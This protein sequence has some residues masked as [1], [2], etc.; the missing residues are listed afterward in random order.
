MNSNFQLGHKIFT[1]AIED[2]KKINQYIINSKPCFLGNSFRHRTEFDKKIEPQVLLFGV[3]NSIGDGQVLILGKKSPD[4]ETIYIKRVIYSV[5]ANGGFEYKLNGCRY[6][7]EAGFLA[8]FT[9]MLGPSRDNNNR[10]VE[11]FELLSKYETI[12]SD[13]DSDMNLPLLLASI[14]MI[15]I[16]YIGGYVSIFFIV[17]LLGKQNTWNRSKVRKVA[18]GYGLFVAGIVISSL[19]FT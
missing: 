8:L 9:R 2:S 18:I 14:F 1:F 10:E 7:D 11:V 5:E 19:L 3:T 17:F 12:Y 4:K 13:K 15:V 6:N 16:G